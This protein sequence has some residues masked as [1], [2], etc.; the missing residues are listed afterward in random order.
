MFLIITLILVLFG[1]ETNSIIK[2][3]TDTVTWTLSQ[4]VHP[5]VLNHRGYY[6]CTVAAS[7]HPKIIKPIRMGQRNGRQIIVNRQ[8]LI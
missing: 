2:T 6:L 3:F 4:Q 8:L 1:Q 7:G 5:P